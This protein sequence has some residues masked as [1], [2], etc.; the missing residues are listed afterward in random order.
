MSPESARKHPYRSELRAQQAAA[1]RQLVLDTATALFIERGYGATSIDLIAETAGVGRSTVFTAA[2][3]K[4]WLLKTA[5]DRAIVGDDRQVPLAERPQVQ[6][7][8]AMTDPAEIVEGY[9]DVLSDAVLRVSRMYEV[10]R[11]AAG[12]DSEV[13]QLWTDIC[14]QRLEGANIIATLLKRK[15]GL[16]KGLTTATARD[17]IWIY[18]DPGMHYAL[19]EGRGWS[20]K[21]FRNWLLDT[22]AHQ[23]LDRK[24]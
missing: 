11:S 10:V 8:F 18:N 14:Q 9:V 5:Y 12:V 7:L 24:V 13:H 15:R 20:Q 2:G 23:L 16:R 1:T 3:G 4:P 17:L 22:F 6:R 21:R 19:V